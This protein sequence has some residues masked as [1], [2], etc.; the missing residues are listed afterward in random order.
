MCRF[1][2]IAGQKGGSGKTVTSVNLAASLALLE[3]KTLLVD[4]DP[5]AR[6]SACSGMTPSTP[7]NTLTSVLSGIVEP[8][9]AV[10]KTML[11]FLNIL[12]CDFNLF[13]RAT[14]LSLNSGNEKLLK[15]FLNDFK[16]QYDYVIID[17]P[18]SFSFLS[19][20]AMLAADWLIIPFSSSVSSIESFTLLLKMIQFIRK[21]FHST[22]KIAGL[23]PV[24]TNRHEIDAFL[25]RYEQ[26]VLKDILYSTCVP[27]DI[28]I[29][30]AENK[31]RPVALYDVST[32][33]AKA[34][35]DFAW[36]LD[37]FFK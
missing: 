35:L 21:K 37:S 32:K 10:S 5:Q 13:Q 28:K 12:P 3:K 19:V 36:E 26:K 31:G 16:E 17:S 29:A 6:S 11:S 27:R 4:C 33:G 25:K 30:E 23:L 9:E 8:A 7:V 34:Y 20:S 14:K 24:L 15:L 22:I 2:T 18:S 1:I